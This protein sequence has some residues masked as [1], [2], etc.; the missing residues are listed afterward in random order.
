MHEN[1]PLFAFQSHLVGHFATRTANRW[2]LRFSFLFSILPPLFYSS[3]SVQLGARLKNPCRDKTENSSG[4]RHVVRTWHL[5]LPR[6]KTATTSPEISHFQQEGGAVHVSIDEN[7]IRD[8]PIFLRSVVDKY[9]PILHCQ[10]PSAIKRRPRQPPPPP[11]SPR[12]ATHTDTLAYTRTYRIKD[13]IRS[14]TQRNP[15]KV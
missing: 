10:S 11:S 8:K 4:V 15:S 5:D 13:F 1:C 14:E 3:F 2:Y 12:S 7:V 6:T 9:C